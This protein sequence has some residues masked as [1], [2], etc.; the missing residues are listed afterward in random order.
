MEKH[1]YRGLLKAIESGSYAPIYWLEGE[2]SFFIDQIA[3]ALCQ[4]VVA[5]EARDFNQWIIYG[6]EVSIEDLLTKVKQFPIGSNRKLFVVRQAQ[7]ISSWQQKDSLSRFSSYLKAPASFSIL[8]FCVQLQPRTSFLQNKALRVLLKKHTIYFQSKKMYDSQLPDWLSS[9]VEE[10]GYRL[11]PKASA[12][13]CE[14]IGNDLSALSHEIEKLMLSCSKDS[15]I[16]DIHIEKQVGIS[17]DFNIFELQKAIA[18]QQ[19]GKAYQIT[20]YLSDSSRTSTVLL[21]TM[22]F[23]YFQRLARYHYLSKKKED[24]QLSVQLGVHPYFLQEYKVASKYYSLSKIRRNIRLIQ[25]ADLKIKGLYGYS[26]QES[27]LLKEL[28]YLLLR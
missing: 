14:S 19:Y 28:V 10:S 24:S 8:V 23:Q 17:K 12:L 22:L 13:L 16:D 6:K 3:D 5:K 1:T 11:T 15:P 7:Q 25:D 26:P 20:T 18:T 27:S 9:Y 21:L 4:R 2:E